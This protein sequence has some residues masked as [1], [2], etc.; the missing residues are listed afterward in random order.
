MDTT[1]YQ[2]N[3]LAHS[4]I[5]ASRHRDKFKNAFSPGDKILIYGCGMIGRAFYHDTKNDLDIIGF[6]DNSFFNTANGNERE[7]NCYSSNFGTERI[8][9]GLPVYSL[10][11]IIH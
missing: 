11:V 1:I 5:R 8:Y 6:I 2:K 7:R 4:Y 3:D 10:K 9:G